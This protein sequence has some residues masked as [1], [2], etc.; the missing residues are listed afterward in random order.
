MCQA[1]ACAKLILLGEHAVL[2]G[3]PALAIPLPHWRVTVTAKPHE[4]SGIC[5]EAPDVGETHWIATLTPLSSNPL[6]LTVQ[7]VLQTLQCPVPDVT[8]TITSQIPMAR[9]L[10]SGTAVTIALMRAL[11]QYLKTDLPPK[12]QLSLV[13][14]IETRYHGQASGIDSHVCFYERPLCFT[15]GSSPSFFDF[16]GTCPL[17]LADT[18]ISPPTREAVKTVKVKVG[19]NPDFFHPLFRTVAQAVYTAKEALIAG[20]WPLLGQEM[21]R[22]HKALQAMGVSSLMLDQAFHAALNAGAYGAK[23]TGGGRGGICV[24]LTAPETQ[25]EVITA[26]QAAGIDHVYPLTLGGTPL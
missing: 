7:Q 23:L 12:S 15:M 24:I 13:H 4:G 16:T 3:H 8:L 25:A 14:Q 10:G 5:L 11:M 19:Q 2:Y 26:V 18:G 9:G 1:S 6:V 21:S 22:N 20:D 17:L